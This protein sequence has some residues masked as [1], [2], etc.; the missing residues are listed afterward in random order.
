MSKI[1]TAAPEQHSLKN[2]FVSH[3]Q[4]VHRDTDNK[5]QKKKPFWPLIV[6]IVKCVVG[7]RD[8]CRRTTKQRVPR[9]AS[10]TQPAQLFA[11][12]CTFYTP[13]RYTRWP[14]YRRR[15][16]TKTDVPDVNFCGPTNL[17][18]MIFASCTANAKDP[19]AVRIEDRLCALRQRKM[20]DDLQ[21]NQTGHV[22]KKSDFDKLNM[23]KKKTQNF[24][25]VLL[26]FPF[27]SYTKTTTNMINWCSLFP[28]FPAH[29][30]QITVLSHMDVTYVDPEEKTVEW[31]STDTHASYRIKSKH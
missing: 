1:G 4:A 9:V 10:G 30:T 25:W 20:L 12:R 22:G 19:L 28:V 8:G 15:R 24:N 14:I 7:K 13:E 16:C 27:W 11:G 3:T 23:L 2:S 31:P 17:D 6:R 5:Q 26:F 29:V 21:R 18:W